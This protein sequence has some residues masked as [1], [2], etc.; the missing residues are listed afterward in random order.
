MALRKPSRNKLTNDSGM[1]LKINVILGV[2]GVAFLV[3]ILRLFQL[4]VLDH[5]KYETLAQNQYWNL[6]TIPAERGD[7]L[8]ADGYVLAGTRNNYLMFA[9]PKSIPEVYKTANNLATLVSNLQYQT[10]E[11]SETTVSQKQLFAD[12]YSR[13]VADLSMN[14][15]WVPLEKDLSE[16]EKQKVESANVPG[17]GF[18]VSPIRFYPEGTL[19]AHVLGF[20]ASDEKGNKQGYYGIEGAL[21]DD[22]A[23]KPGRITQETDATGA[24]ILVGGYREVEPIEGRNVE[25]TIN[26]SVQYIIEKHLQEGVEKYNATSG[27]VIVMDP[28]TGDIIGLANY[29]TYDP[30]NFGAAQQPLPND[31]NRMNVNR[32]DDAISETYEP[33]SVMKP[34]TIS[35][36]VNLGLITPQTTYEDNGPVKYSNYYINNWDGKHYGTMNII[37]LLQK[38]NNIGAAWVGHQVGAENLYKYFSAFGIGTKTGVDLEGEDTGILND[39]KSWTDID[40]ATASFGQGV[41][42]TPLQLLNAYNAIINGGNLL[43]PK[44]ISKIIDGD[45]E[46][47]IPTKQIAQVVTPKTSET[48]VTLLEQAAEG[49]EAKYFVLKNYRIGG[50][51]GTAQIPENGHYSPDQ[52][53]ATFVGFMVGSKKFSMLVKLEKPQTSIYAAETAVPLWMDITS[54]LVK[55]Y[56]LP[57]DRDPNAPV[58]SGDGNTSATNVD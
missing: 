44:I 9:E 49:G 8:S 37:Q 48:M 41:S 20:V 10:Q 29:P 11:T 26:R 45:K 31:P 25:L 4:Q 33:G 52:T 58:G 27:T 3:V 46:I 50:K 32:I 23:G 21:N 2:F 39:Y 57:P 16:N 22:L 1:N 56:G 12:D 30:A 34:L 19:A 13:Y 7:I 5:D 24:P 35:S 55:F 54:D 15:M 6:Q 40:I 14:L 18:D 28:Y 47:T 43:K 38:S 36:A 17:I 53:N 42:V 51:T